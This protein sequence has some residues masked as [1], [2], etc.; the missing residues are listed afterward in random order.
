M[1]T[2]QVLND[3]L[4]GSVAT[5]LRCGG[6]VNNQ[7]NTSLCEKKLKLV[8]IW[9]SDKQ[10]HGCLMHFARLANT[11]LKDKES[12]RYNHVLACSFAKY[13]PI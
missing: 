1:S 6:V 4:H 8:N 13:S 2:K 7:I 3:K 12:A 9:Q 11:L 5:Y 10:E